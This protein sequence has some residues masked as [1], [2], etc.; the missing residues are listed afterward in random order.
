MPSDAHLRCGNRQIFPHHCFGIVALQ[1]NLDLFQPDLM[2]FEHPAILLSQSKV[3]QRM[4]QT[5][6]SSTI[7]PF[8][9]SMA[10]IPLA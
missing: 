8:A 4:P 9:A 3:C 2:Q 10:L 5:P 1:T 7:P 6:F